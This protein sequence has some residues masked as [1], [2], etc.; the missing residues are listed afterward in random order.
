MVHAVDRLWG[1]DQDRRAVARTTIQPGSTELSGYGT[2]LSTK[3]RGPSS[4][5][6]AAPKRGRAGDMLRGDP[7]AAATVPVGAERS[8]SAFCNGIRGWNLRGDGH[9][10]RGAG[11]RFGVF[12]GTQ[13]V[14]R[15]FYNEAKVGVMGHTTTRT[16]AGVQRPPP[17][18]AH[19]ARQTTHVKISG[20]GI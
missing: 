10:G 9:L 1:A 20:A 16:A 5:A 14:N 8:Q 17:N 12:G 4:M 11:R 13:T 2:A 15:R 3:F 7:T 6:A 18:D 19:L